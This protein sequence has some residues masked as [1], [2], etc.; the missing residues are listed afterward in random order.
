[1]TKKYRKKR[2]FMFRGAG[3][4]LLMAE[5]FFC[6]LD[7]LSEGLGIG[8]LWVVFDLKI[9]IFFFRCKFFLNF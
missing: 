1:M 8:K 3:C 4:S 7:V 6:G 9:F 5:G 2:K